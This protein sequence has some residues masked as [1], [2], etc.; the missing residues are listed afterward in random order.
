MMFQSLDSS[1]ENEDKEQPD[2]NPISNT[3]IDIE[4]DYKISN[5]GDSI[6][7][8]GLLG[9]MKEPDLNIFESF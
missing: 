1:Q 3:H 4:E 7:V 5:D 8:R 6:M 9:N 2:Q